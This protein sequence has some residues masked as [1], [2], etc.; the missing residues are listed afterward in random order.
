MGRV[1]RRRDI[2][3]PAAA[4]AAYYFT[5]LGAIGIFLPFV[6]LYLAGSGLPAERVTQVMALGPLA[7]LL[8]PPLVG[9]LADLRRARVGLLR[10]GTLLTGLVSI[11]F[12]VER[13]GLGALV[14][15]MAGFSFFR[16]P[17]LSLADAAALDRSAR[18]AGSY[19]RLRL[20]G[21]LG[22]LLAVL[23]GGWLHDRLGAD[24][25]M[26]AC[27]VG[28][29]LASLSAIWLSAPPVEARPRI[30]GEW[31]R[32]L[33]Q[34]ELWLFL[35]AAALGQGAGAAYDG[36]F[37][38]HLRRLGFDGQFIGRAWAVGVAAEIVCMA[39]LGADPAAARRR[40]GC[41]RSAPRRARCAGWRSGARTIPG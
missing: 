30:W 9:L 28:L 3:Q 24:H 35:A 29:A 40:R 8:V 26:V 25:V 34:R 10:G 39:L 11:G 38:M 18:D 6:S 19:G 27:T 21:S 31:R 7:G 41:S 22:F 1:K 16:A 13:P 5:Y 15:T 4:I 37:S 14:A 12:V 33:A 32:M 17:L 36:G 2:D 20:W 23:G